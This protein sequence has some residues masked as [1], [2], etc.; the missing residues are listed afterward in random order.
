[1]SKV[2]V[3]AIART[4]SKRLPNKV[5]Y[6][7]GGK[8]AFVQV[9]ERAT[10]Y[11]DADYV[12]VACTRD[13]RDDPIELFARKYGID[14]FRGAEAMQPRTLALA[15][16]LGLK[17]DDWLVFQFCDEALALTAWMPWVM[18][19]MEKH[20]CD[21]TVMSIPEGTL[22]HAVYYSPAPAYWGNVRQVFERLL[23]IDEM[24]GSTFMPGRFHLGQKRFLVVHFPAEYLVP[25][26]W[27]HLILD[28]P[29]QALAIKEVYRQLYKGRPIDPLEVYKLFCRE[30]RLVE[31]ISSTDLPITTRPLFLKGVE[32]SELAGLRLNAEC[33][34]VTW[35]PG[36]KGGV[37]CKPNKK[38]EARPTK[39]T[40]GKNV[41]TD[42]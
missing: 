34:D 35:S 15:N 9:I 31:M 19:Q 42:N 27:G 36:R 10:Y 5:V 6:D 16:K 30:P 24:E 4:A 1:M 3:I 28:H 25:W 13:A 21:H 38:M 40:G 41:K 14:C 29:A 18:E 12:F 37:K 26:P 17:E 20:H 7:L 32:I 8:P 22:V 33:V 39:N 23:V 11:V 2:A